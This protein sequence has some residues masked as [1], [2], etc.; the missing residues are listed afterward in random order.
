MQTDIISF[1]DAARRL[2]SFR[3]QRAIRVGRDAF[4][5]GVY[6]EGIDGLWIE[7]QASAIVV[8]FG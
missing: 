8:P 1:A 3:V 7:Q 2:A 6:A 5:Q 4:R